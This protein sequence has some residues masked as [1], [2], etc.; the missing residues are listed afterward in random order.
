MFNEIKKAII[1][2]A[3]YV[4]LE[5][6][7][8]ADP[9]SEHLERVLNKKHMPKVDSPDID[10]KKLPCLCGNNCPG[11]EIEVENKKPRKNFGGIEIKIDPKLDDRG[12]RF[13]PDIGKVIEAAER[14]DRAREKGEN[15][16]K[17]NDI[18]NYFIQRGA[19]VSKVDFDYVHKLLV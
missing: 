7:C 18:V 10:P 2:L 5:H 13:I 14:I 11:I 19:T 6:P 17:A 3:R 12:W 4:E 15:D 8:P 9:I 1:D 16:E